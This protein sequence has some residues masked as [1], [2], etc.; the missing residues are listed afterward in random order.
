MLKALLKFKCEIQCSKV[1]R[2]CYSVRE[3][4]Q[5]G[6]A[7][8]LLDQFILTVAGLYFISESAYKPLSCANPLL[9]NEIKLMMLTPCHSLCFFEVQVVLM[10]ILPQFSLHHPISQVLQ[11]KSWW[12]CG[13]ISP[14]SSATMTVL[15]LPSVQNIYKCSL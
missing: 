2:A 7:Q 3:G 6:L 1:H 10:F 9:E 15:M 5:T 8:L 12:P 13:R 11:G 14:T 4:D